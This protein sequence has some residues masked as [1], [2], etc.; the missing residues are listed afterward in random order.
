MRRRGR[1][2]GDYPFRTDPAAGLPR[3]AYRL[4]RRDE[5]LALTAE[6]EAV[7]PDGDRLRL[8]GHA[9]INGLGAA[10]GSGQRTTI[11]ALRQG[12]WRPLRLRLAGVRLPTAPAR[13]P[14]LPLDR[15]WSGFEAVLDPDA[16]RRRGR[17]EP[18]TWDLYAGTCVG[19]LRR[20]RARFV[21]ASPELIGAVDLPGGADACVRAA[22]TADGALR[23]EVRTRWARLRARRVSGGVLE[24][25]GDLR[26]DGVPATLDLRRRSDGRTHRVAVAVEGG[27]FRARV[28]LADVRDAPAS[29]EAAA[30]GGPGAHEQ[31]DLSIGGLPVRLPDDPGAIAWTSKG[32]DVS[33]VRTRSGDAA[34]EIRRVVTPVVAPAAPAVPVLVSER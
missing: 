28:D 15:A 31:W 17:W 25:S 20:R 5:D 16:L 18:G 24:L 23:V 21:L 26:A 27:T 13:R 8:R 22:V 34:V 3:S 4:G 19:L 7:R 1:Y 6:L 10:S 30:V 29:L 11:T 12:R 9:A 33:L 2:Y 14:D 32:H